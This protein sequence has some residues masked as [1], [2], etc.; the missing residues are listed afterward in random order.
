MVIYFKFIY[1]S[2]EA[3]NLLSS[4]QL[5]SFQFSCLHKFH[6]IMKTF[7]TNRKTFSID[8]LIKSKIVNFTLQK[9]DQEENERQVPGFSHL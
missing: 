5:Q 4:I 3:I 9:Q 8:D 1:M 2:Q 7:L 6:K